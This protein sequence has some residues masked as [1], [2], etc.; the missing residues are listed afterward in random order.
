[1]ITSTYTCDKRYENHTRILVRTIRRGTI[2]TSKM[3]AALD[4]HALSGTEAFEAFED[5]EYMDAAALK[6]PCEIARKAIYD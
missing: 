5:V 1:M 4:R 6:K 2:W 3:Q